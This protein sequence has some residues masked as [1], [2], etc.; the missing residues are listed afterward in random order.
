MAYTII[1]P[2][3][4]QRAADAG[5]QVNV[6]G[7]Y[8][9]EVAVTLDTG[10][11]VAVFVQRTWTTNNAGLSFY[12]SG[13][14]INADGSTKLCVAGAE[15]VVEFQHVSSQNEIDAQGIDPL[16]KCHVL[17]ILGEPITAVPVPGATDGTTMPMIPW[18]EPFLASVSVRHAIAA[19]AVAGEVSNLATLI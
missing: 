2:Q 9:N 14:L 4:S 10:E 12:A 13:R 8:P 5:D 1:N 15:I 17:A 11:D 3:P 6:S 16:T 18:S 7:L 19:T